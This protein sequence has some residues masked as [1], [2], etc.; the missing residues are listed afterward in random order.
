MSEETFLSLCVEEAVVEESTSSPGVLEDVFENP[1]EQK[2]D[3]QSIINQT[4]F[5]A[6]TDKVVCGGVR[7]PQA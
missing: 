3:K 1:I 7:K 4:F 2:N 6:T 5:Q